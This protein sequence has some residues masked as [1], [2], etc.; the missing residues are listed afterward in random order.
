MQ[1]AV[2]RFVELAG[3]VAA[4]RLGPQLG[5]DRSRE[6]GSRFGVEAFAQGLDLAEIE[7]C[8]L[9]VFAGRRRVLGRPA[10]DLGERALGQDAGVGRTLRVAGVDA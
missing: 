3:G 8:Q 1:H 7:Q 2:A 10:G 5:A 9:A 6:L 4:E